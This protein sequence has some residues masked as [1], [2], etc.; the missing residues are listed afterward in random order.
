VK[1]DVDGAE[2]DVLRGMSNMLIRD[3]PLIAIEVHSRE[4]CD[5]VSSF[6]SSM[7]YNYTVV[8]APKFERRPIGFNPTV[9]CNP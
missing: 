6:M 7:D 3:R 9:Y 2:M 8:S 4:L 5:D 1:I